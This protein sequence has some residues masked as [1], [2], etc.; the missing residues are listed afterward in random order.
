ML[1]NLNNIAW[2]QSAFSNL[3]QFYL[4]KQFPGMTYFAVTPE[5]SEK[6]KR[7]LWEKGYINDRFDELPTFAMS[8]LQV[9]ELEGLAMRILEAHG[10]AYCWEPG[11]KVRAPELRA[12]V[13]RAA[14]IQSRTVLG[15]VSVKLLPL[16]IG[17]S[18]GT[19]EQ[20]RTPSGPSCVGLLWRFR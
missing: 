3:F 1:T 20:L 18:K 13:G 8:P 2:Q 9:Q 5:F 14:A 16:W 19:N 7:R 15:T 17:S 12:I 4:G 11:E 10:T 6:C